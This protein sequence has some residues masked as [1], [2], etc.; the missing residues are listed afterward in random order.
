MHDIIYEPANT[1]PLEFRAGAANK[2]FDQALL[3]SGYLGSIPAVLS[4]VHWAIFEVAPGVYLADSNMVA[5][6]GI[7]GGA[8]A[9]LKAVVAGSNVSLDEDANADDQRGRSAY[10]GLVGGKRAR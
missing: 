6:E 8:P 1:P 9:R 7:F 10:L 2:T 3:D 4:D 5:D